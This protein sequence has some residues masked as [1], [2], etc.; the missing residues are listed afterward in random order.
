MS[1]QIEHIIRDW[2]VAHHEFI[3]KGLRLCR[4]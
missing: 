1:I 2:I 4:S 3:E